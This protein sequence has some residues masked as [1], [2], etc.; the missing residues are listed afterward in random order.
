MSSQDSLTVE[1]KAVAARKI[2]ENARRDL[3]QRYSVKPT[4]YSLTHLLV[5][6]LDC[7]SLHVGELMEGAGIGN[8]LRKAISA[9]CINLFVQAYLAHPEPGPGPQERQVPRWPSE[10]QLAEVR[11]MLE[12]QRSTARNANAVHDAQHIAKRISNTMG[13][14]PADTKALM[15]QA[16]LVH[17]MARSLTE[18][19]IAAFLSAAAKFSVHYKAPPK[20]HTKSTSKGSTQKSAH[21]PVPQPPR[22][23][24]QQAPQRESA[25]Q[26]A[27]RLL[28]EREKQLRAKLKHTAPQSKARARP[29]STPATSSMPV[30]VPRGKE[31]LPACRRLVQGNTSGV[32]ARLTADL[33][34]TIAELAA[35]GATADERAAAHIAAERFGIHTDAATAAQIH[36]RTKRSFER[37]TSG[38]ALDHLTRLARRPRGLFYDAHQ[39]RLIL[40]ETEDS[41]MTLYS[42]RVTDLRSC[43]ATALELGDLGLPR[44]AKRVVNDRTL[45]LRADD[46]AL[47]LAMAA[48]QLGRQSEI[49]RRRAETLMPLAPQ[50]PE[51]AVTEGLPRAHSSVTWVV[52]VAGAHEHL[53]IGKMD[54]SYTRHITGPRSRAATT[55]REH[56]RRPA[57]SSPYTQPTIKVRAHPRRGT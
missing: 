7:P 37:E 26:Q 3:R 17:P 8:P 6:T 52:P 40:W 23:P 10:M 30:Y 49:A 9:R 2:L 22:Q 46:P 29:S 39:D 25:K 12:V 16:G 33:Y 13:W 38:E 36:A 35:Y 43:A 56:M 11:E 1:E 34:L 42:C 47:V 54:A 55:V 44:L 5:A 53:E 14:R 18:D 28:K 19:R 32:P 50:L 15:T 21:Q 48:E 27:E 41:T 24:A 20:S 4:V 45:P 31:A 51:R 57:G